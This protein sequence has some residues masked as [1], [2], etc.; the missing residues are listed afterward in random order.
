MQVCDC[1]QHG[2]L[3]SDKVV[4]PWTCPAL[5]QNMSAA[6]ILQ[7]TSGVRIRRRLQPL[8]QEAAASLLQPDPSGLWPLSCPLG[9]TGGVPVL[10][11]SAAAFTREWVCLGV[12]CCALRLSAVHCKV[13]DKQCIHCSM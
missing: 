13:A 11:V 2:K 8:L 9:I 1:R 4:A 7:D 6:L 5:I 12:V 3:A 10:P